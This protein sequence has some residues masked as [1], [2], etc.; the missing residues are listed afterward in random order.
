MRR[1]ASLATAKASVKISSREKPF[2]NFSLKYGVFALN[3]SSVKDI[4][5]GSKLLTSSNS[6]DSRF[7]S[8]SFFVP[9]IFFSTLSR[10][11]GYLLKKNRQ[12]Y[13]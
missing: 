5:A 2:F 8:R 10:N 7:N 11:I 6:D 9:T 1:E 13:R 4:I 3:S 12:S